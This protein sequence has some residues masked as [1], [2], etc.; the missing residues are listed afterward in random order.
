VKRVALLAG[1]KG[2]RLNFADKP[3]LEVCGKKI[4]EMVSSRLKLPI[5]VVCSKEKAELYGEIVEELHL[6]GVKIVCDI[7]A[8]FGPSA[9]I[10]TALI[11]CGDVVVV[12]GDMPFVKREVVD[13]LWDMGK[14]LEC[15]ALIPEWNNGKKEPLLAYYSRRSIPAFKKA[16]ELEE[17]KIMQAVER[18]LKPCYV[19]MNEI[20]KI[21]YE[22][23]S[24]FNINTLDDLR[25]AEQLCSSTDLVEG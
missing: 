6:T 18:M 8:D 11:E 20:R 22:L 1:G 4:I 2:S 16:I 7:V 3:L 24:F 12:A 13:F 25:R 23:I 10:Y 21:D 19:S 5:L 17:R 9:G 15:D 14:Q